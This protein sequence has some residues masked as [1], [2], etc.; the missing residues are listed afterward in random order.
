MDTMTTQVLYDVGHRWIHFQIQIGQEVAAFRLHMDRD[1]CW[2]FIK[3]VESRENTKLNPH[4]KS[5]NFL[6]EGDKER[7]SFDLKGKS[8]TEIPL[9]NEKW[10]WLEEWMDTNMQGGRISKYACHYHGVYLYK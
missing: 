8:L 1:I 2:D 3:F 5:G 7:K 10:N 6:N 4:L 9:P